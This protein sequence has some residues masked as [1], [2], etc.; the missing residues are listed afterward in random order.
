MRAVFIGATNVL[1]LVD[2]QRVSLSGVTN[3]YSLTIQHS[4]HLLSSLE[5]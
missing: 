3:P 5:P 2:S 1:P 4:S